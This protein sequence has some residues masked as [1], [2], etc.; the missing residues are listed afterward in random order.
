MVLLELDGFNKLI[1]LL[2]LIL[3]ESGVS[4]WNWLKC[5]EIL[6]RWMFIRFFV[7]Y[8]WLFEGVFDVIWLKFLVIVLIG[9]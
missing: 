9:W 8:V 3:R 4:V 2:F 1:I 5:L 7:Y 6:F